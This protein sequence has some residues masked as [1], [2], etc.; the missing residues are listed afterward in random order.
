MQL[1]YQGVKCANYITYLNEGYHM[2]YQIG[3]AGI[4][5][6]KQVESLINTGLLKST[7]NT[8][9]LLFLEQ[10]ED[11]FKIRD[12]RVFTISRVNVLSLFKNFNISKVKYLKK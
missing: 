3:D 11:S 8:V 5:L 9:K 7:V 4:I 12:I 2:I 6:F 1:K 10:D